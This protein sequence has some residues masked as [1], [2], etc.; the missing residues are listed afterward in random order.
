MSLQVLIRLLPAIAALALP[1]VSL[2]Q[3]KASEPASVSQ[4]IDG[5]KITI[6]Y[7]RPR[8]RARDGL[9]GKVVTWNE[10]WTPGANWATTFEVSKGLKVNG[11]SVPQGKYSVW[12]VVRSGGPWTVVLDP[13]HHL[14]H[15]EHPDSTAQQI[16][17]DVSREEAGFIEA[18]SWSFGDVRA[19][20]AT[21]A[22]QWGTTRV[23]LEI[24]VEPSYRLAMPAEKA[25]GY[26][27]R[28][29]FEMKEPPD[30]AKATT[31]TLTFEKGSLIGTWNPAP[32]PEWERF[33]MIPIAETWFIPGFLVN[34]A[35]YEVERG[36]VFEFS[37]TENRAVAFDMR[38]Q[39]DKVF[40]TGKWKP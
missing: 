16:R 18:L 9:F 8:A 37:V 6:E 7:S 12:M 33:I 15:E 2:S 39:D 14:F 11:H 4:T 38:G 34:G 35:L 23:P 1:A 17:F 27:G 26:L 25:A 3:V 10:V 31:L 20:G 32:Y 13:R 36:M 29:S 5:T 30:T 22:M 28:Y 40:A 19:T 21:L 24:E